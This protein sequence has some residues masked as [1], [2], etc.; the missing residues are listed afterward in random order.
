FSSD[1]AAHAY[2]ATLDALDFP[3]IGKAGDPYEPKY[4]IKPLWLT[5]AGRDGYWPIAKLGNEPANFAIRPTISWTLLFFTGIL[6]AAIYLVYIWGG[7]IRANASGMVAFA[8]VKDASRSWVLCVFGWLVLGALLIIVLPTTSFPVSSRAWEIVGWL[9]V[10]L[11]L[12]S[13]FLDL[14]RREVRPGAGAVWTR[15]CSWFIALSIVLAIV[16][17]Q[18]R[19]PNTDEFLRRHIFLYRYTHLSSGVSPLLPLLFL[20]AGG[21]W[22]AWYSLKGLVVLDARRPRLP[23]KA[24][25]PLLTNPSFMMVSEAGN[26]GLLRLAKPLTHDFRVYLPP[27]AVAAIVFLLALERQNSLLIEALEGATYDRIYEV[28]LAVVLFVLTATLLQLALTWVECR[29]LLRALDRFPLRRAFKELKEFSWHP[30]WS[31]S[32]GGLNDLNTLFT[33]EI[34]SLIHLYNTP[35]LLSLSPA[36][37]DSVRA[38]KRCVDDLRKDFGKIIGNEAPPP[39]GTLRERAARLLRAIWAGNYRD[40]TNLIGKVEGLRTHLASVCGAALSFLATVWEKEY[41]LVLPEGVSN[42]AGDEKSAGSE[43]AGAEV[44]IIEQ[45]VCLIYANFIF[46]ILR[47]IRNLLTIVAGLFVFAV[48]SLSS[49]PFV[50]SATIRSVMLVLFLGLAT[51]AAVVYAQMHGDA[52]LGR[53]TD[54]S[55]GTLGGDF[56]LRMGSA[57]GL[58]LIGLLAY[59]F[60]QVNNLLFSWLQPAF[61][62]LK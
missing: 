48:L 60:P 57:V 12:A 1:N 14:R 47:Q 44:Q 54:T 49:Y 30:I 32:A 59:Q 52:T 35:K 24:D 7:S 13:C 26:S 25:L 56:W 53:I 3:Q 16:F 5:V 20:L 62:A 22:W 2:Y 23:E 33:R 15:S 36:L 11:V 51:V 34:E 29:S 39:N 9:A 55:P 21:L 31:L 19:L 50:P 61:Q 45:F 41:G 38:A 18:A 37:D 6:L 4:K 17:A 58:P 40:E 10:G 27:L 46:M 43:S 8:P 28:A 42:K